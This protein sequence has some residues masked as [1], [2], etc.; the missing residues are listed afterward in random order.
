MPL[1]LFYSA[2]RQDSFVT[3]TD[4]TECEGLYEAMGVVG[5]VSTAPT[6]AATVALKTYYN[7]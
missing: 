5:F 3:A 4:C 7:G 2:S 1:T 6:G